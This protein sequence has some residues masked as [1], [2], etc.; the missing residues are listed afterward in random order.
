MAELW[1]VDHRRPG[2]RGILEPQLQRVHANFLRQDVEHALDR[3]SRDRGARRPVGGRFR[4]ITTGHRSRCQFTA[5]LKRRCTGLV[6]IE[7]PS[8]SMEVRP[9]VTSVNWFGSYNQ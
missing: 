6:R 4:P 3:K 8:P 9:L 7:A 5:L 1:P 2:L